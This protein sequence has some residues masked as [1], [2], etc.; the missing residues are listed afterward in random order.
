LTCAHRSRG[1]PRRTRRR[2]LNSVLR[3]S[4]RWRSR[5]ARGG[6]EV[7][8]RQRFDANSPRR[9]GPQQVAQ[10]ESHLSSK[11][12]CSA[13]KR[14]VQRTFR[15]GVPMRKVLSLFPPFSLRPLFP[16]DFSLPRVPPPFP[17]TLKQLENTQVETHLEASARLPRR[18]TAAHFLRRPP[19]LSPLSIRERIR[20]WSKHR[21]APG[22]G[23]GYALP[24]RMP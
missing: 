22:R 7:L 3:S 4:A 14:F 11:C 10:I 8:S 15:I 19:Q 18:R 17:L 9:V 5:P 21:T 23:S 16:P 20:P 6:R 12:L 1:P 2:K 13:A 24:P